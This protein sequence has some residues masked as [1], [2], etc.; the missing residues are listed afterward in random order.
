MELSLNAKFPRFHFHAVFTNL[1]Q[2]AEDS[3]V[4]LDEPALRRWAPRYRCDI[5][6][7]A[8]RGRG[9]EGSLQRL[10]C[11][12][13]W[14]KAGSVFR[15][16]N[17]PRGWRFLC[18]LAW[19]ISA[20]QLRKLSFRIAEDELCWNRDSAERGLQILQ[21]QQRVDIERYMRH[22]Q[23]EAQ[24]K[25]KLD[26][27][28][29][30]EYD[31]IKEWKRQYDHNENGIRS[32]HEFLVL[33]GESLWGKTRLAVSIYGHKHTYIV[34]C[35][36]VPQPNL[37]GFDPRR[38]RCIVLDEPSPELVHTCK[39]LLQAG[40]DGADMFQSPTQRFVKWVCLFGIPIVVCTNGWLTAQDQDEKARWIR[41]NS[42]YLFI[43]DF[44]FHVTAEERL[45][46]LIKRAKMQ[47]QAQGKDG[48]F[49]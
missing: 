23:R 35:Q 47:A 44:T 42:R 25:L 37:T 36:R 13:Q 41:C 17:Y 6:Q 34:N 10:H 30:R 40:V 46:M 31:T 11:Y 27:R 2:A 48:Y 15:K 33:E 7:C 39:V 14:E 32:R 38:H 29:F 8:A 12:S 21:A 5:R 43:D 26:L 16:T 45:E 20:W 1:S 49:L 19:V 4:I 3:V 24:N 22:T 9:S 28:T 18:K